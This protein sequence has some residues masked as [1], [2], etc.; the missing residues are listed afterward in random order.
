MNKK[1]TMAYIKNLTGKDTEMLIEV[2]VG[3]GENIVSGKIAPEQYYYQ[4]EPSF[5][6]Q[7][8]EFLLI[9]KNFLSSIMLC[10]ILQMF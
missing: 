10:K 6:V 1:Q 9:M 7:Q 5:F 8:F 4:R 3:L 2:G